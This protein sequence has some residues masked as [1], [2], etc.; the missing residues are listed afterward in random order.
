[1]DVADLASAVDQ[2]FT[3]TFLLTYRT[4]TTS[5]DFFRHLV[6]RYTALPPSGL[7]QDEYE[8]WVEKKQKL[9]RIRCVPL[10][11]FLDHAHSDTSSIISVL[12]TWIENHLWD[13]DVSNLLRDVHDFAMTGLGDSTAAQQ[14]GRVV[15]KVSIRMLLP[16]ATDAL[17]S[18]GRIASLRSDHQPVQAVVLQ[19]QSCLGTPRR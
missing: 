4:F 13:E 16:T 18:A 3:V 10:L 19:I 11:A 2:Q 7:N 17:N 9:I 12:K 8:I 14:I 15:Q 1:M 5:R 6:Q